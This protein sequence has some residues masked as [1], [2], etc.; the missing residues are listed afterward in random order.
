MS[1]SVNDTLLKRE[2]CSLYFC[3]FGFTISIA[4]RDSSC[5]CV[6]VLEK[7]TNNRFLCY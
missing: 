6:V 4:A 2:L 3:N 7:P 1:V 5:K